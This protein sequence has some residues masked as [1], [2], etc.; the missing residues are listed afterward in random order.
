L[1]KE[2]ISFKDKLDEFT[3]QEA[4][5]QQLRQRSDNLFKIIDDAPLQANLDDADRSF[6]TLKQ[7]IQVIS[8]IEPSQ[9]T[10][11]YFSIVTKL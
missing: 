6:S 8:P 9:Y 10:F 4:F 2:N 7:Q 1:F 5:C 11:F 3:T